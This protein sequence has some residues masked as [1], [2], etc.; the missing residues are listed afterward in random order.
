M[1]LRQWLG[2]ENQKEN[3]TCT[4]NPRELV[5]VDVKSL[6]RHRL[7]RRSICKSDWR[8]MFRILIFEH[9]P[10]TSGASITY[11]LLEIWERKYFGHSQRIHCFISPTTL[12]LT[13]ILY[14]HLPVTFGLRTDNYEYDRRS[15]PPAKCRKNQEPFYCS[16]WR[17]FGHNNVP[18]PRKHCSL[19]PQTAEEQAF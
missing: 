12:E 17:S 18:F 13:L 15:I 9:L 6:Q 8:R 14:T 10:Q 7:Q 4:T 5:H 16:D 11:N 19:P 1:L 3:L 2:R